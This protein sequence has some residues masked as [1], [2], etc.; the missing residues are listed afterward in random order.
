M[1][2]K[3]SDLP[4][5]AEEELKTINDFKKKIRDLKTE[6]RMKPSIQTPQKIVV[7]KRGL[8]REHNLGFKEAEIKYT[9]HFQDIKKTS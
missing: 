2:S 7:D 9:K 3:L 5:E 8:E 6:L 4:K 1:I